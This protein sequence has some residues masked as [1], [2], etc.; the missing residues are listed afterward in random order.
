MKYIISMP[1]NQCKTSGMHKHWTNDADT[2]A[3][4]L[5]ALGQ[6]GDLVLSDLSFI[7]GLMSYYVIWVCLF[8]FYFYK[9]DKYKK[10]A[11]MK[12]HSYP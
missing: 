5:I 3:S 6:F 8:V 9:P 2:F 12:V 10:N 4:R 1:S 7:G 11:N